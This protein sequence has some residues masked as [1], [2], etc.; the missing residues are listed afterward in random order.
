MTT[1]VLLAVLGAALL[2][3]SWNAMAK[4]RGGSDPLG[5]VLV[6]GMGSGLVGLPA[7]A[8]TGLP[9][10]ESWTCMIVSAVV[11]VAYFLLVGYSYRLADYSAVYPLMRG[12]APLVTTLAGGLLLGE[13]MGLQLIVGVLLLGAGVLGLGA[14][15]LKRGGLGRAGLM[16]AGANI[17][18]IVL[19][20][21]VDGIGARLSGNP[22]AYVA[23]ML[24]LTAILLVPVA[25]WI[26]PT[27]SRVEL[28]GYA[29]VGLIGG[30]MAGASYAIALWAMT[31]APIGAV[32]A[33]R[34]TSVLFGTL[35][36][37]VVLGERFGPVRWIAA[38]TI[39]AGLMLIRLA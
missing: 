12:A 22:A 35:I 7:M 16:V 9:A 33:L 8:L 34:E 1:G 27:L 5:G 11:H 32:A 2:H 39:C 10:A 31:L 14:E 18:V 25:A 13:P 23:A 30:A 6:L 26:R 38:A 28:P 36:A 24:V 19:Y 4:G 17:L 29:V 20:T 15:A 21:L 3:A 37:A